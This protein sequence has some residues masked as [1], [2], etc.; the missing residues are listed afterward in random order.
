MVGNWREGMWFWEEGGLSLNS[1]SSAW[2]LQLFGL[3][4]RRMSIYYYLPKTAYILF[5]PDE[6]RVSHFTHE[7]KIQRG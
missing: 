6:P 2:E 3:I 7:K 5:Q 4:L 1:G